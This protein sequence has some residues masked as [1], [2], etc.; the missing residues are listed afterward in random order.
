MACRMPS[1]GS[2]QVTRWLPRSRLS[3]SASAR[4]ARLLMVAEHERVVDRHDAAGR[5][6]LDGGEV[7]ADALDDSAVGQLVRGDLELCDLA[8]GS[9]GEASG[10]ATLQR[11][12]APE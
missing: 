7:L 1:L 8:P 2:N 6:E 12:I 10:D 5:R 4:T 3:P 11:R 9:D